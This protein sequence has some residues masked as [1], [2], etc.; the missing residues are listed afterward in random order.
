MSLRDYCFTSSFTLGV[1]RAEV[2]A[3]LVDLEL[4]GT[5]WSQVRA[6]A[7]IDD[8]NALVVCRSALP[9]DLE[10]R[11]TAERRDLEC[12]EVAIEGPIAGWAKFHL[13]EQGPGVTGL[14]FEQVV[15]A[16][17]PLFVVA[18]YAA[19]PLLVWNHHRMM[20]GA[21]RGLRARLEPK[22][23][24]GDQTGDQPSAETAAS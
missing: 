9:Y 13:D 19:R 7:K 17:A 20:R 6:V 2:H 16:E 23:Q 5:W 14:R 4:Y 22:D 24:P 10:L 18:S 1:P 12:L 11:L 8:D 15:R 3:V 21:E